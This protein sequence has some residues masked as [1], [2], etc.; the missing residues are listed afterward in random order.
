MAVKKKRGPYRKNKAQRANKPAVADTAKP[1]EK[2]NVVADAGQLADDLVASVRKMI[3]SRSQPEQQP[4]VEASQQQ[5]DISSRTSPISSQ[6]SPDAGQDEATRR[7]IETVDQVKVEIGDTGRTDGRTIPDEPAGRASV[8]D[9]FFFG[10][11]G[12]DRQKIDPGPGEVEPP[13]H[14]FIPRETVREVLE[15]CFSGTKKPLTPNESR[16]LTPLT[17]D[18]VNVEGPLLFGDSKH[19]ALYLWLT[20]MTIFIGVRS[21]AGE[22]LIKWVVELVTKPKPIAK[23]DEQQK[24]ATADNSRKDSTPAVDVSTRAE[25]SPEYSASSGFQVRAKQP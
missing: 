3:P 22:K 23:K 21:E 13:D 18:M 4:A 9:P 2:R 8:N 19:K 20:V 7:L 11:G 25:G 15:L 10:G 5:S 24:P 12:N 16:A 1:S 14:D 17:V 6:E